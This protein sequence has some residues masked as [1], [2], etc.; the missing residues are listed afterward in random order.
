M[1]S[2]FHSMWLAW[3]ALAVALLF[4]G[5][6]PRKPQKTTIDEIAY[7]RVDG[8]NAETTDLF[9]I[10]MAATTAENLQKK[11]R[12]R[13][14]L[15]EYAV[16][17]EL[18]GQFSGLVWEVLESHGWPKVSG[19]SPAS[20]RDT[21]FRQLWFHAD[22]GWHVVEAHEIGTFR[23][24]INHPEMKRFLAIVAE[25]RCIGEMIGFPLDA[26]VPPDAVP[27]QFGLPTMK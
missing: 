15:I 6:A 27:P 10:R 24:T 3:A 16:R 5:C 9:R 23:E 17:S 25:I 14:R 21:C 18:K 11:R 20:Q 2:S 7:I 22:D 19:V 8:N 12:A 13:G 1:K 26:N 4:V